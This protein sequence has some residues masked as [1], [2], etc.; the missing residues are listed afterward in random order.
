MTVRPPD[1]RRLADQAAELIMKR[2][3]PATRPRIAILPFP[4]SRD[5]RR[6]GP[7]GRQTAEHLLSALRRLG[8]VEL[9]APADTQ[10]L[11]D[12]ARTTAL[13]VGFDPSVIKDRLDCDYLLVGW[14]RGDLGGS[15][16][17][18]ALSAETPDPPAGDDTTFQPRRR[19][20]P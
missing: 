11:I 14:L 4:T 7:F 8:D 16:P 13:A 19:T 18:E 1:A 10:R 9:I 5:R 17:V 15:A 6:A 2:M 20:H 12:A 3:D